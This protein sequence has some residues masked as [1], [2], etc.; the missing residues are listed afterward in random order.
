MRKGQGLHANEVENMGFDFQGLASEIQSR[1]KVD[2]RRLFQDL[3]SGR[4][5]APHHDLRI[6]VT[7]WV[8][9]WYREPSPSSVGE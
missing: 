9:F 7:L 6:T 1:F 3:R 4:S 2:R 5:S 8:L